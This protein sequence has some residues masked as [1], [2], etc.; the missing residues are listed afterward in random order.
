MTP[1]SP[2]DAA[3]LPSPKN[4][5]KQQK[6]DRREAR[7]ELFQR[8]KRELGRFSYTVGEIP[9]RLTEHFSVRILS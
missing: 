6:K 5:R 9:F 7:K 3:L 8:A 2:E 1:K 4:D